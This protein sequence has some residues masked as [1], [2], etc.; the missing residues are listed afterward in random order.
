MADNTG[1]ITESETLINVK[2]IILPKQ[3]VSQ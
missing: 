2:G 3:A 1:M